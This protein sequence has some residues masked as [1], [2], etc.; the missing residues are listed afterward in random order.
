MIG[1][2]FSGSVFGARRWRRTGRAAPDPRTAR[3]LDGLA[4]LH[5]ARRQVTHHS[6]GLALRP[7]A[8]RVRQQGGQVSQA[9]ALVAARHSGVAIIWL[10]AQMSALDETITGMRWRTER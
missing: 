1:H 5:G 4:V 9:E 6:R 3:G 2:S 10:V 8:S 7:R